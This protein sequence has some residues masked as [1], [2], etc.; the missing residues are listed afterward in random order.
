MGVRTVAGRATSA[1]EDF[2]LLEGTEAPFPAGVLH[3]DDVDMEFV[4]H[5]ILVGEGPGAE[6]AVGC[7]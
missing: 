1:L 4:I 2:A 3:Q 7:G 5:C 6:D